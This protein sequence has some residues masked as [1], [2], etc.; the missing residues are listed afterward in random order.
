MAATHPCCPVSLCSLMQRCFACG[1][2]RY[3]AE[4]RMQKNE[5]AYIIQT[6]YRAMRDYKRIIALRRAKRK[7]LQLKEA[8]ER[9]AA[10]REAALRAEDGYLL[11]EKLQLAKI[12]RMVKKFL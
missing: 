6:N 3:V 11:E 10:M 1:G 12:Q 2:Q 5:A 8:R 9:E 7:A 4:V